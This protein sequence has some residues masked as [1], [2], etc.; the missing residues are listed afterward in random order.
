MGNFDS[1]VG[2]LIPAYNIEKDIFRALDSCLQ[3]TYRNIEVV[4]VDDGSTDQ[5]C[6]VVNRY[7]IKDERFKLFRQ[8]NG[9]VSC[10]RNRA[11]E[12]CSADYAVF[13]DSDDWLE[14]DAIEKYVKNVQ[15]Y[16]NEPVLLASGRYYV[17]AGTQGFSRTDPDSAVSSVTMSSEE[18]LMYVGKRKYNLRN[19]GYKLY[20]MAVIRQYGLRFENDIRHGEDGLFVF[21]YLK[22]VKKFAYVSEPL[23]NVYRRPGS[24][25]RSPYNSTKLSAVSAVERMLEY[26]NSPALRNVLEIYF[27]QRTLG[28]LADAFSTEPCHKDDIILLR[29]KLKAKLG[30]YMAIQKSFKQKLICLFGIFAPRFIARKAFAARK[31][32]KAK[33]N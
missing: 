23:W 25:C 1:K 19:A 11:L 9:G 13:L 14:K 32:E 17:S 21:E 7:C 15:A 29:K 6:E 3:Q 16:E 26:D 10:A 2:I 5:T 33:G 8:E 27:V 20:S 18:A 4:V 28:I 30:T 31:K 12:M 22:V 24:A